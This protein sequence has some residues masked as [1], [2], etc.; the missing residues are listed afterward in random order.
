MTDAHNRGIGIFIAIETEIRTKFIYDN[1]I[2]AHYETSV[3]LRYLHFLGLS[4]VAG[5]SC[6]L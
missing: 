3:S 6:V 4:L 5:G 2:V 1:I